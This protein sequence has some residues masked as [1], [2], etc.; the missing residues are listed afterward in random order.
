MK[1]DIPPLAIIIITCMS[2][3]SCGTSIRN[4]LEPGVS[5]GLAE[6]RQKQI[7]KV[8]YDLSFRIPESPDSA[9]TGQATIR[10]HQ[11]RAMVG[12]ILDFQGSEEMIGELLVNGVADDY[13]AMNGHIIIS[14]EHIIP[15]MN[16]LQIS[17]TASDQA[18]NRS[19]DFMYTLFV[20]DKAST[21]FPC[22][23]QPDIKATFNLSLDLPQSW[24]S[25]SNSPCERT[26]TS[27]NRKTMVFSAGQPISTYLFAFAAGR[28][29]TMTDSSHGRTMTIFHR[30]TDIGK[31][32]RNAKRI[33]QQ[34]ADALSWLE[35]YTTIPYPFAKL[36]MVL[37]PGFQ[38]GGMEHP[39]AIYYRDIRVLL[40]EHAPISQQL[41]KANL[42]AHET[43][44]M[45]FGDLV[46]MKWFDDVWLK[47]VFAGFMAD[48][49]VNPQFPAVNHDLQFLLTHYPRALAVDRTKGTHPIK[50]DLANMKQAGSLY[51]AIIYNKAPIVF[52]S[53]ERIMG[54][55][56][57]RNAVTEYLKHYFLDN[58]DWDDLAMIFDAH[59]PADIQAWSEQ[60][61]YGT[62]M[63]DI[64]KQDMNEDFLRAARL[65]EEH[66][67]FLHT[68]D[69]A[70]SYFASLLQQLTEEQNPQIVRYL[71]NTIQSI[72][73]QFLS[74]EERLSFAKDVEA[75]MW[76]RLAT[77][78][79]QEKT[80]YL[81]AYTDMAL[82][83]EGTGRL[84]ALFLSEIAIEGLVVSEE[85]RFNMV[86]ACN[87][88]NMPQ[89]EEWTTLLLNE[90]TNPD[91]LRRITFLEPVLS[92]DPAK[93]AAF[94]QKLKDPA[95]RRPEP[96]ALEGLKIL[97]HPLRRDTGHVYVAESL[98]ML[99]EIQRT[100]DIFF[101]LRWLD[102]TLG[103]YGDT[104]TAVR[105][106]AYLANHPSLNPSL[107]LKVLQAADLLFRAARRGQ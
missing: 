3:F 100:G 22:F 43:A 7:S 78:E 105:V 107:R 53:L 83:A 90:T 17:F 26:T 82:T 57:F 13:E 74:H 24:T 98:E 28:F 85:Q 65:I 66:E 76:D 55:H 42:I 64:Y 94:F 72:Y 95:N 93:R 70:S 52:E 92:G 58:A 88:R 32:E 10:F 9:I 86:V 44:H 68:T 51:G 16:E 48:K 62:G 106:E 19:S 80:V 5:I 67:S 99:E 2:F 29:D 69:P 8:S 34:H 56:N 101:P 38:Y 21:A 14:S 46:T 84:A 39:G 73:W 15:S 87:L 97:H 103:S 12:V 41:A 49:I 20:P 23:D 91:R 18:L 71:I 40:D 35:A 36:D 33:F 75:L 50:Q 31:L 30:E 54:E 77:A 79:S 45:W 11:A 6:Y 27:G 60:W 63:P 81:E 47:E 96:W 104:E 102:A 25:V 1:R 61:I 37:I 89:A 4:M 59:T